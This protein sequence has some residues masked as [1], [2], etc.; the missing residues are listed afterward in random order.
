MATFTQGVTDTNLDP[1]LFTPDYSFLR[2]NLEKKTA[3]Y[4]QGLKS[5][6][7]SYNTLK[8]DMTDPMNAQRRDEFLKQAESEL[9][10]IASADLSLQQNVNAANAV[11]QPLVT[12]DAI[13]YDMYHTG[14][15]KRE[16]GEM[17]SW[18]NSDDYSIRKKFN[19]DIYDW[20]RK[21]LESLKN[22]NGNIQN[23][24]VQGRKSWAYIDPQD[25]IKQEAKD[26]NFSVET[27]VEGNPY[28]VSF[29]GGPTHQRN[30]ES[31]AKSVL[32]SNP[33]YK[34]Q[35][36]IL[37]QAQMEKAVDRIIAQNPLTPMTTEQA[38]LVFFTERYEQNKTQNKKY[39]EALTEKYNTQAA[40]VEAYIRANAASINAGKAE[41][42]TANAKLLQLAEFKKNLDELNAEYTKTFGTDEQSA[43]K[44]REEQTEQ[45]LDNPEGY[46]AS[47]MQREDIIRFSNIMSSFG[48]RK[49]KEDASYIHIMGLLDKMRNTYANIKDDQ[50]DNEINAAELGLKGEALDIKKAQ[51]AIKTGIGNRRKK[52]D[53]TYEDAP[54]TFIE[55]SSVD[56]VATNKLDQLKDKAATL[57]VT[58]MQQ[59]SAGLDVLEHMGIK[60]ESVS[61]V[62]GFIMRKA[63]D[64]KTKLSKDEL[65]AIKEVYRS[66]FEWAKLNQGSDSE[67]AKE[68][69][70]FYTDPNNKGYSSL[71]LPTLLQKAIKNFPTTDYTTSSAKTNLA[72]YQKSLATLETMKKGIDQATNFIAEKVKDSPEFQNMIRTGNDGKARLIDETDIEAAFGKMKPEIKDKVL[73]QYFN[74]TLKFSTRSNPKKDKL[75][76]SST[77]PGGFVKSQ[78]YDITVNVDGK[79]YYFDQDPFSKIPSPTQYRNLLKKINEKVPVPVMDAN[80]EALVAAIPL[81]ELR[82]DAKESVVTLL[83]ENTQT[84]SNIYIADDGTQEGYSQVDPDVQA[85]IRAALANKDSVKSVVLG[86]ASPIP[87]GKQMVKIVLDAEDPDDKK[88]KLPTTVYFPINVRANSPD[89]FKYFAEVDDASQFATLSKQNKPYV[90]DHFETDGVKVMI[91]P[92]RPG[93]M[94]GSIRLMQKFDPQTKTYT[95]NWHQVGEPIKVD[96]Q[97]NTFNEVLEELTTNY[98]N[99]YIQQRIAYNKKA[100]VQSTTSGGGVNSQSMLNELGK[101]KLQ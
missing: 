89:V 35:T 15:I 63:E 16:L 61:A 19:Q 17:E 38:K 86:T 60:P 74:G 18:R 40:E 55:N 58:G 68:L 26:R 101:L 84:N 39:A 87:G 47:N 36:A 79:L 20:V 96:F 14:R 69:R 42:Q 43:K 8:K 25:I 5:V 44:K 29:K 53:G 71:D 93:S 1:V 4:E 52:A 75:I 57:A 37:A 50:F 65:P 67:V 34:Q 100:T 23:Y 41:S 88:V 98:I 59:L 80:N 94:V 9:Q 10:K 85:K 76:P 99:P 45:F 77:S 3:Q 95:D 64:P 32:D 51:L 78:G 56:L 81:F 90:I 11:F 30:Y 13:M 22:G 66:L 46:L 6:V 70:S 24:K 73:E 72:N 33:L 31:F 21:D 48:S 97:K 2:Y 27:D 12:D 83:K 49:I 54:V 62:R 28:I 82:A 91:Y 92:E 7:G